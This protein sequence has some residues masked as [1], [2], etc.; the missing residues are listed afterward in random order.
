M[1]IVEKSRVAPSATLSVNAAALKKRAENIKVYNLSAGE[2]FVQTPTVIKDAAEKAISD[3][4]TYYTPTA[5][6]PELRDA[7]CA[8]M[9]KEFGST[10][11][12]EHTFVTNG[13]K[14]GLYLLFQALLEDGDEVLIPAP[15]WVSYPKMVEL[16]SGKPVVVNTTYE[17]DWKLS[18][19]DLEKAR[20]SKTKILVFNNGSNPTGVLYTKEEV[21]AILNWAGSHGIIVISDEVYAKL[22]YGNI[23]YPS[24][25]F[26]DAH[27]S[28][29]VV[30]QSTSKMFSMTGW[31]V[32]FVFADPTFVKGLA[33]LQGQSTSG[34]SSV[35]QWASVAA[36]EHAS[37]IIPFIRSEMQHRRD[38]LCESFQT[39]FG[40]SIKVPQSAL[41]AFVPLS[42]FGIDSTDDSAF[43]S[44]MI[45]K[46]HVAMVPGSAF[47]APGFV[48][49]SFGIAKDEIRD[50][51]RALSRHL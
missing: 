17:N 8:W 47:G 23:Q 18:V 2:A 1:D 24:C 40:Q 11:S 10:Y 34:A 36:F 31:R 21:Q 38:V 6:I 14:F 39:F 27:R 26:F 7:A 25:A 20:N 44:E 13:G 9:N 45:E 43:C 46:A 16:F 50:G 41:Y 19:P 4:H 48:R 35:A 51:V 29:V 15:Y 42:A 49:M 30:L 3:G 32:G 28:H 5:G 12:R 22:V 33:A 37:Q